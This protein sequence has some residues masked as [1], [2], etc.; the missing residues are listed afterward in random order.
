MTSSPEFRIPEVEIP[1]VVC[2]ALV[3][4]E[5]ARGWLAEIYRQD[6]LGPELAPVMSYISLTKP[7]VGRGPHAHREQTDYFCF[8]GPGDFR[9]ILWDQRP[10]SPSFGTRQAFHLGESCPGILLVPPGVVHGYLNISEHLGLVVNCA[11]RLYKGPGRQEPVDEIRYEN[12]P[13][14]PFRLE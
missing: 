6:E 7:G 9:V 14:C 13:I 2:R 1:G 8:P 3:I 11:N 4:Y 12:D 5:D 10:E